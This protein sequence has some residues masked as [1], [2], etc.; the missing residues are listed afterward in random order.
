MGIIELLPDMEEGV[1]L[2]LFL[3]GKLKDFTRSHIKKLILA[4]AVRIGGTAV[5]KPSYL[6]RQGCAVTVNIPEVAESGIKVLERELEIIY[7][8]DSLAVVNKP[9][10][11]A[12]HPGKG[13]Y[14]NTLVNI[15]AGKISSLSGIGGIDRPGIVHRLDKETSGVMIIAKSDFAHNALT[16]AFKEREIK[17]IY[18][19]VCYGTFK[20]EKGCVEGYIKRDSRSRTR[21]EITA[22][23]SGKYCF[24]SFETIGR[25]N[26]AASVLKV[27]P[28]TGRTHQIRVSLF[29]AGHPIVGDK[30]YKRKDISD[31]YKSL[32]FV[33]RQMLHA[34]SVGFTHPVKKQRMFFKADPPGDMEW[35]THGIDLF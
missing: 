4:G 13:N 14:D 23:K 18:I 28:E 26:G 6:L 35:A 25:A 19:A 29:A 10:G 21:M 15:L 9:A 22:N 32:N 33:G 8:D 17:K 34:Y 2:D 5:E 30:I 12:V 16:A 31:K 1:R 7:E 20:E 3:A 24:T 11:I 27:A